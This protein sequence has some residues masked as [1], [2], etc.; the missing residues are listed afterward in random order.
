MREKGRRKKEKNQTSLKERG[1]EWKKMARKSEGK[2][3]KQDQWE[4][5]KWCSGSNEKKKKK[6][7][8][9][10]KEKKQAKCI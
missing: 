3:N 5:K 7:E 6:K 4:E 9:K 10:E 8:R 2:K 1:L